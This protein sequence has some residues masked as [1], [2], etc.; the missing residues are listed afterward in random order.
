MA[1][2]RSSFT[3]KWVLDQKASDP[4][5]E[6][7]EARGISWLKR[8]IAGSLTITQELSFSGEY[9]IVNFQTVIKERTDKMK[10]DGTPFEFESAEFG[11]VIA[12]SK[13]DSEVLETSM[14]ANDGTNVIRRFLQ[15]EGKTL[16]TDMHYV[17]KDGGHVLTCK[18]VFRRG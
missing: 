14:T 18:R 15:D 1:D 5:D 2:L 13:F 17:S 9:F 16:I 11:K 3:G 8:K 4:I 12:Y 10:L 6:L 7:L